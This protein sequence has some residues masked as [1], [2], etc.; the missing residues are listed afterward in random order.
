MEVSPTN[1]ILGVILFSAISPEYTIRSIVFTETE[2]LQIP[3]S[4]MSELATRVSGLPVIAAWLLEAAN[5]AIFSGLGGLVGIKM[6]SNLKKKTENISHVKIEKGP[7]PE[8]F[9]DAAKSRLRYE[10]IKKVKISKVMMSTDYVLNLAAGFLHTEN[11]VFQEKAMRDV[12]ALLN[13]TP[14]V[15]KM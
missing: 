13:A 12:T 15:S 9:V 8:E 7:L 10:D 4:K 11:I 2:V 3:I 5:P 1:Q 14:L 6:W